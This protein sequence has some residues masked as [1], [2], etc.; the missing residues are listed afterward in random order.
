MFV[1]WWKTV[2][3]AARLAG[4]CCLVGWW[5]VGAKGLVLFSG[6]GNKKIIRGVGVEKRHFQWDDRPTID[7]AVNKK[8]GCGLV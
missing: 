5:E 7:A 3:F 2:F 6:N 4:V 1:G 8:L